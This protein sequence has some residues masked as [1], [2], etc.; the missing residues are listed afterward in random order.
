MP[1]AYFSA[2][3]LPGQPGT[4]RAAALKSSLERKRSPLKALLRPLVDRNFMLYLLSASLVTLA[5]DPVAAFQ[6]LYLHEQIG[7]S[8]NLVVFITNGVLIGGM[9]SS[10]FWGWAADRYGS[11]PVLVTGLVL[12][13][14][15]PLMLIFIPPSSM[16]SFPVAM[17]VSFY[18]GIATFAQLIGSA[19][20][21]VTSIIPPQQNASFSAFY[22]AWLGVVS[23]TAAIIAGHLLDRYS[24]FQLPVRGFELSAYV[25]LFIAA[26]FFILASLVVL[27]RVRAEGSVTV[28]EF[29]GMFYQGN[30]LLAVDSMIRFRMARDETTTISVTERLGRSRSPLTAEELL[31]ALD[32]PRFY[33]RFEALISIGRYRPEPRLLARVEEILNGSDPALGVIAAWALGRLGETG[34][35][36]A[37]RQALSSPYRSIQA[38]AAR[39][40][41]ALDD[42]E[43]VPILLERLRESKDLGL[44]VA[45]AA[46][47]GR[48][49]AEAATGDLLRLLYQAPTP[50][51]QME[52]ALA[53]ARLTGRESSFIQLLR[54]VRL[55]R[56]TALSQAVSGLVH[57]QESPF[58][59]PVFR[60]HLAHT[61]EQLAH[62]ELED[63][64]NSLAVDLQDLPW[65]DLPTFKVSI[66][67]ECARRIHEY[68]ISRLEY[69]ILALHCLREI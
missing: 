61:A 44:Q 8:D 14:A 40:L 56:D 11:K 1:A 35:I 7:L 62:G 64:L 47:L 45:Y 34:A 10:F 67:Q 4:C 58:S 27:S 21:V 57:R 59:D 54:Q 16:A 50:Q 55:D 30:P 9:L 6:P 46:A 13:A 52:V 22:N 2:L 31:E 32:D 63:G 49:Q 33:V 5:I 19:R 41:G 60:E 68:G 15:Y 3:W 65:G 69:T 36:P 25:L 12:T 24:G 42:Q 23:G 26:T 17:L 18:F 51:V 66:L 37:L 20:L 29:A 43:S 48:L 38:H 53:V 39:S 28:G